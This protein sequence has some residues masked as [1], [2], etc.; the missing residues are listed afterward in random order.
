M[1]ITRL[2][3]RLAVFLSWC[4]AFL[5]YTR[6]LHTARFAS[7]HEVQHL[8]TATL[9]DLHTR[10]LF[11]TGR[12]NHFVGVRPTPT[13]QELGNLL[14]CAPP[15]SG[16]SLLAVS[17][18]LTW[19]ASAIVNDIKGELFAQTAGW[20]ATFGNVYVIDP[21]A[22]VGHRYDPFAGRTTER[23]LYALA[24]HLLF[25]AK[26]KEPIFVQHCE[27]MLTQMTRAAR[28]ENQRAGYERYRMLPYI[29]YLLNTQ[30]LKGTAEHLH[31]LSPEL[32]TKFLAGAFTDANFTDDRFLTSCWGTLD[33]RLWPLMTDDVIRCFDGQDFT[34]G[35]L[36]T[37]NRPAT[38]YIRMAESELHALAPLTRLLFGSFLDGLTTTYDRQQPQGK[39]CRPVLV[40]ADEAGKS[41][42]PMLTD[43][44]STVVGRRIYLWIAVQSLSQLSAAYGHDRGQVLRDTV[45]TSLYFRPT[46]T[47]TADYLEKRLGRRSDYA[48]SHTLRDGQEASEGRSEQGVALLTS[49]DIALLSDTQ[50]LA[51]HRDNRPMR[52]SRLDWREHP[53]L[54]KRQAMPPPALQPLPALDHIHHLNHHGVHT[55]T[56]WQQS[57]KLPK[58]YI[59]PDK[60]Y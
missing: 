5:M 54:A 49:Q 7:L 53:L 58:G 6:H 43:A 25:D 22:G 60:R 55:R 52:L 48:H 59:D 56:L 41:A 35:E 32:A 31:R 51:F 26:D 8:F 11:G 16:K 2:L 46:D 3:F 12:F 42:I 18:L 47:Q 37:G 30:G 27:K 1:T 33:A 39:G 24:K 50:L 20:R 4:T 13:W 14:I 21:I 40:M 19:R 57:G 38:V 36:M 17:Q 44:A 28:L 45:D 29:G 10:L 23:E 15:R 34:A 9:E